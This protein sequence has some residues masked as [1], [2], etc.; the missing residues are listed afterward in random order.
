MRSES[1]PKRPVT[2]DDV[3]RAA[4]VSQ[5]TASR[6]LNGSARK[7]AESYRERVLEAARA[8]GYTPNLPAQ[9]MAR[10]TS[11]TIALVTSLI[12]DPYFG[13][14]AA[15]ILKQ[16]E[17]V[18]LH[19]SIAVTERRADR[20]LDLVRELRGQQPRAIILAGSGSVDPPSEQPLVDELRRY[21]ETGGRVVLISRSD[22]PFDTVDFDNHEGARQLARELAGIGYRRC[23]VLGSDTPLLSMR[24]R[25][26]GFVH[27]LADAG[28]AG[29]RVRH[30]QFSWVGARDVVLGLSNDELRDLQLVFAVTDD[31]ALGA[32]AGLRER[33]LRIPEDIGVAGFDDITTLRDVVPALTTVHVA[34]DAVAEEAVYRATT[35]D[36]EPTRRTVPAYPVVRASTPRLLS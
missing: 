14:L 15:E 2:L 4:G 22:L 21:E 10:G 16:A 17:A 9:A 32:L 8:L 29:A 20:E 33:G 19:V 28:V 34:L 24:R 1:G 18:G 25:V 11:R 7:V 31:M 26:E 5:P 30:P 6:V 3:A 35:P 12:S 27:G 23:L 36:P 13:A